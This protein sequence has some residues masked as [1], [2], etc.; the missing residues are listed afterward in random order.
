[1][2]ITTGT[3]SVRRGRGLA[4]VAVT[5]VAMVLTAVTVGV[6]VAVADDALFPRNSCEELNVLAA[7]MDEMSQGEARQHEARF[8]ELADRCLRV[9][10]GEGLEPAALTP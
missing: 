2:E 1:M 5:L 10:H 7:R 4:R 8:E 3:S 6:L 9:E